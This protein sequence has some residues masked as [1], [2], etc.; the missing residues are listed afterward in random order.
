[1]AN[2]LSKLWGNKEREI[3]RELSEE[4]KE[5]NRE[6]DQKVLNLLESLKKSLTEIDRQEVENLK[7][8]ISNKNCLIIG[9]HK[10]FQICYINILRYMQISQPSEKRF[11]LLSSYCF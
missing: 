3:K 7:A 9:I 8:F 1:M 11:Q 6:Y 5:I 4:Q 10:S 2:N